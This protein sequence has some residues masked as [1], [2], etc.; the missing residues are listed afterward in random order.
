MQLRKIFAYTFLVPC[1]LALAGCQ[2]REGPA[3]K[4]GKELDKAASALGEQ[5]ESAGEQ[6][7]SAVSPTQ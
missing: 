4:A 3:E 1:A 6:I 7:Q 5:I 2:E